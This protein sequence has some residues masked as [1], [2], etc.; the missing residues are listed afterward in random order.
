MQ[1]DICHLYKDLM[2]LYGDVGNMLS[3]VWRC[4]WRGI[5]VN[6]HKVALQEK[7]DFKDFD[8]LFIGGCQDKEQRIVAEDLHANKG[9]SIRSAVEDGLV[10][11]AI[12]A[13]YQLFGK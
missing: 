11:L 3:L 6:I 12:C 8:L 13:G 4:E 9:E 2:N 1:L 10:V 7:V 5:N